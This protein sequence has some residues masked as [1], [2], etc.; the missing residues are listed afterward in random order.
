MADAG[1]ESELGRSKH[2]ATPQE[3]LIHLLT[4]GWNH[5][6]PLIEK[7]VIQHGLNVELDKWLKENGKI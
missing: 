4:I 2:S 1:N 3:H 6:T 5:N 7:F